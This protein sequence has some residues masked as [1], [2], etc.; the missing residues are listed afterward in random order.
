MLRENLDPGR[1]IFRYRDLI[2]V[3]A[4]VNETS[5]GSPGIADT[6][7]GLPVPTREN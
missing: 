6:F 2:E 4:V 7:Q 5:Q 3:T 1:T